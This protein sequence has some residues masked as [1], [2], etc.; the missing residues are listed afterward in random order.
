MRLLLILIA[1][2]VAASACDISHMQNQLLLAD[3]HLGRGLIKEAHRV[4]QPLIEA[5]ESCESLPMPLRSAIATEAAL[6]LHLLQKPKNAVLWAQRA[7]GWAELTEDRALQ[8]RTLALSAQMHAA[9]RRY[10][11]AEPLIQ[12]AIEI[13]QREANQTFAADLASCYTVLA[14]L[15]VSLA[16]PDGARRQLRHA[17]RHA[18]ESGSE[19]ALAGALQT[20]AAAAW[21]EREFDQSRTHLEEAITLAERNLGTTH[22]LM[23]EMYSSYA[24]VLSALRR[25]P[26]ARVYR[27][28]AR[29]LAA[30]TDR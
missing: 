1:F 3:D 7:L 13:W 17:L 24:R 6:V 28:R 18:R 25:K 12:R 26:E 30:R 11:D 5:A 22:P 14:S 21:Q 19:L 15:Y 4:L 27:E 16:D 2:G 29:A 9:A 23:T 8:A 10:Y 20:L